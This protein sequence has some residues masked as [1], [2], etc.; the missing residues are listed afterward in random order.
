MRWRRW[1][2][3]NGAKGKIEMR[4][5]ENTSSVKGDGWWRHRCDMGFVVV[6]EHAER[7]RR[8]ISP[9]L[10]SWG[11]C[12]EV[13][14]SRTRHR[15]QN[16]GSLVNVIVS[17]EL[18]TRPLFFWSC[19]VHLPREG[20]DRT[21]FL[22]SFYLQNSVGKNEDTM[23]GYIVSC[24]GNGIME[25][26]GYSTQH[27]NIVCVCIWCRLSQSTSRLQ[28][29]TRAVELRLYTVPYI[30]YVYQHSNL[31]LEVDNKV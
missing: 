10:M 12:Y 26:S 30:P 31:A 20:L 9:S 28:H 11:R 22:W 16:V 14:V 7:M 23:N 27:G 24:F 4:R 6:T 5:E 18:V 1:E 2:M 17:H 29:F 3:E 15:H 8:D 13:A 25:G 21:T 19:D